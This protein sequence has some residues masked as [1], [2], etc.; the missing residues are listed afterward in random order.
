VAV[1]DASKTRILEIVNGD[2]LP[3][4]SASNCCSVVMQAMLD[5]LGFDLKLNIRIHKGFESGSGLG[6][7]SASS[8]AAAFAL[9]ELL[10]YPFTKPELVEFAMEGERIACGS[11]HADNVAPS[12]LGGITLIRS[13]NPI[14]I[15]KLPTPD[16]LHTVLLFPKI[17]VN[18][19]D[20][21]DILKE[22]VPMSATAKQMGNIATF[23][24]G[25]YESDYDRIK[26]SMEDFIIEPARS[27][28]IPKFAEMKM[29]ALKNGAI[30]FGISGSG[31]SVFALTKGKET[32]VKVKEA[33][34]QVYNE[35]S[36][37]Y[38]SFLSR[39]NQSGAESSISF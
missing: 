5:K 1:S 28:L 4:E 33:I 7:S 21:R 22:R 32:S 25:L 37:D 17:K 10:D 9:N 27:I 31:P 30:G 26:S 18:T 15:I 3:L 2:G 38:I 36:I 19:R 11:A 34:D 8:A 6:S 39:V 24:S 23:V 35:T 14:D 12:I 13:Y 20:A 16:E 29:A